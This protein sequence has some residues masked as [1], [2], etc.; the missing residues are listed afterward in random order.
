MNR[1]RQEVPNGKFS[2]WFFHHTVVGGIS[3]V[4]QYDTIQEAKNA[5]GIG[6]DFTDWKQGVDENHWTGWT[7]L[8]FHYT[9]HPATT[10]VY[11]TP[12]EIE[13]EKHRQ[14]TLYWRRQMEAK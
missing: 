12:R 14:A 3:E 8:E 6:K 5:A 10:V 13:E 11:K 4:G 9:I 1:I 2:L 7:N